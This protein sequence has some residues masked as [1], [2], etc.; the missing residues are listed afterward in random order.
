M[1]SKNKAHEAEWAGWIVKELL[2]W[3]QANRRILPWREDPTPYHILVSEFML[4]QTQVTTVIPYYIRFLQKFPDFI[5]LAK[6]PLDEVLSLWSGLGYYQRARN[7]QKTAKIVS[8]RYHGKFPEEYSQVLALP[9]IGRYT[10]GAILSIAFRQKV[11]LLDGNV[12]RLL[13]RLKR[14]EAPVQTLQEDLW[15][16]SRLLVEQTK[17]PEQLNQAL[18]ELPALLC[19]PRS[20]KC[21]FCPL[22]G[23]CLSRGN[24]DHLPYKEKKKKTERLIRMVPVIF[25]SR[26]IILTQHQKK[27]FQG[28]YDF[29]WLIPDEP[30]PPFLEK[31]SWNEGKPLRHAIMNTQYQLLPYLISLPRKKT[32]Q[33]P[34]HWEWYERGRL[35]KDIPLTGS[36]K[37]ILKVLDTF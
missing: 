29:P 15:E 27:H 36:G 17:V 28:I 32:K 26:E 34:E 31:L 19:L 13:T 16:L 3:Y 2:A 9:G 6:A 7:L 33:L 30:Y 25:T 4:Q 21:L 10:A 37:K 5:T 23:Q 8:E 24:A 35:N 14:L 18:M 12:I 11:P 1:P 20:P 22:Q